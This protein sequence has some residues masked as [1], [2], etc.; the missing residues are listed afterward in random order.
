MPV[1]DNGL[2]FVTIHELRADLASV[3]A[4]R[5]GWHGV[6]VDC[7]RIVGAVGTAESPLMSN[8]P[9]LLRDQN[10]KLNETYCLALEASVEDLARCV[11]MLRPFAAY[12]KLMTEYKDNLSIGYAYPG[13]T[14]GHCRAAADLVAEMDAKGE[15]P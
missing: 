2:V 6:V 5:D 9:N 14:V 3:T 15:T 1:T 13:P 8:L 4:E 12:S 7:E 11:E 10:A